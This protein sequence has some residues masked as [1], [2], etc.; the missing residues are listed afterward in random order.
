MSKTLLIKNARVVVTMDEER[1]EIANGAV[2][3][4]GNVIEQVGPTSALPH[5]ADEIIDAT[6]HVVIPGLVNTH[7]HMYQSLTRVIPAAQDGELF[8]WLTNLY[9]IWANLDS[10]MV[11]V[12]T[13]TAMAE[14]IL[15]G[16]TT[17]SD[18]LYIYP[19]DCRLDDSIEAAAQIGMRFHAARGAMSVGQSKGGLPPDCVVE[20]EQAILR[21]TQRLIETYHDPA[22]H[23]MQRIV[24]APCSPFSVSRDLMKE[25]A[26]L[27]RSHGVSLHTHLA[28]NANDIAYSREK[29]RM[30]PAQYAEDCGWVG[31]DV[32]HA[33]CVQLD[34]DGVYLFARTG[35]GVAHCPCSN[36]RLASGIAPV[37]KM[38]DAGVPVGLGVDGSA[39]NDGAHMLGEVR[40]A[41]LL[42][43]VG[44]GPDAMTA[45]QALELATLGGAKVLNRD[46]IGAIKPGMSADIAMFKLD[47][48]GFAG[49]LHDPVAALV[50]CTPSNVS[51][52]IINGKVVV[53]DGILQ[54]IDLPLVVERHNKLA[55]R[56]AQAAGARPYASGG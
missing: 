18:H 42:Q 14:L 21:D 23:A 31:H 55:T 54:T 40:Q 8:N 26:A 39:S 12:S 52:S 10:E 49:A 53:R 17:S 11:H 29:F 51:H 33:H 44:F 38:V 3:V 5:T 22:R 34:D 36:M 4:R 13:L 15:S 25:A 6:G 30:T 9:P 27:A 56:L 32:W 35:T 45:R 19:N 48:L 46:D 37:R 20:D 24:V 41:M 50:F 2:Y 16:C 43:R 47:Q 1:R 7:H 28:E